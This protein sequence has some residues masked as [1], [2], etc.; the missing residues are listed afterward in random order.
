MRNTLV[1]ILVIALV[2]FGLKANAATVDT[3]LTHSDA[4]HKDIKAVVVKPNDYSADKKFPGIV[5]VARLQWQL[6]RLDKE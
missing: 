6:C 3:A 4:M 5:P 2:A 1:K